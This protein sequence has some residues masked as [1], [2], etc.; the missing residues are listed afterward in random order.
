MSIS[1][2]YQKILRD[3]NITD[4]RDEVFRFTP[5]NI[6]HT[7]LDSANACLNLKDDTEVCGDVEH[8]DSE[9]D[10]TPITKE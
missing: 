1:C 5:L 10:Y 7:A 6:S 2:N 9:W 3:D 8:P 4:E